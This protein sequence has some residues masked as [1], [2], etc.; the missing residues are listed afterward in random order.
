MPVDGAM[1]VVLFIAAAA[2]FA[3]LHCVAVQVRN[4]A[5]VANLT[6][7]VERLRAAYTKHLADAA[8]RSAGNQPPIPGEFDIVPDSPAQAAA[9]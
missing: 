8:A 6:S 3:V 4:R 2:V 7:E 9:A 1:L 5:A